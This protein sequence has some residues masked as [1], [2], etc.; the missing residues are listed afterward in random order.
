MPVNKKEHITSTPASTTTEPLSSKSSVPQA[1]HQHL[2][3]Q[4]RS[5][6]QTVMEEVMREELTQFLGVQ[7]EECSPE[8]RGYRNGS[9][10]HDLAT[11]SG[12]IEDLQ[13]PRDREGQFHIQAF[14]RYSRYEPQVAEGLT[15]MFVSGV[16][17][18]CSSRDTCIS[19]NDCIMLEYVTHSKSNPIYPHDEPHR[20]SLYGVSPLQKQA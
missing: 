1:F 3:E 14:E 20:H 18:G 4:I 13:V 15:H 11:S 6:G 5:A 19:V 7:W 9:Y 8:R 10:T 17:L 2:R 12:Q 16:S